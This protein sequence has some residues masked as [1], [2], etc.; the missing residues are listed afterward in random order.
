MPPLDKEAVEKMFEE[1]LSSDAE[2]SDESCAE[3][4]DD[5]TLLQC[6]T[7]DGV[8]N[9][10]DDLQEGLNVDANVKNSGNVI[11]SEDKAKVVM[12]KEFEKSDEKGKETKEFEDSVPI[13]L[14]QI[15]CVDTN[16]INHE[17]NSEK[18]AVIGCKTHGLEE[19]RKEKLIY[20]NG[21]IIEN[22]T[23]LIL[24]NK[25]RQ[26]ESN[27]KIGNKRT[28]EGTSNENCKDCQKLFDAEMGKGMQ[29][30]TEE[31]TREEVIEDTA[32]HVRNQ[33]CQCHCGHEKKR[34]KL[35][36]EGG[37]HVVNSCGDVERK[38]KPQSHEGQSS[39]SNGPV[40]GGEE[41]VEGRSTD[42]VRGSSPLFDKEA[43]MQKFGDEGWFHSFIEH[44][45]LHIES[46]LLLSHLYEE[47]I[48]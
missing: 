20:E 34:K 33:E 23:E 17:S 11:E 14:D 2:E 39:L 40:T 30:P 42:Q 7:E 16:M 41:E 6:R 3:G 32:D 44:S 46:T 45:Q 43:I 28:I 24:S 1:G 29:K 9:E 18:D 13:H 15:M 10:S 38:E 22:K 35:K 27:M 31:D 26:L 36:N 12:N 19:E 5:A 47:P 37:C 4:S 25:S 8:V 48:F 21:E